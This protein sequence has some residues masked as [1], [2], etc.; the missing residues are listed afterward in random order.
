MY[1]VAQ[2]KGWHGDPVKIW[3]NPQSK[4]GGEDGNGGQRGCILVLISRIWSVATGGSKQNSP[5]YA[6]LRP[7]EEKKRVCPG[8]ATQVGF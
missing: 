3:G 2:Y 6:I 5:R 4:V 1:N 8:G 7:F